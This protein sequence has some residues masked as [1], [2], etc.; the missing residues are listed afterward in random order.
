MSILPLRPGSG[1]DTKWSLTALL[2]RRILASAPPH[3]FEVL[4]R[5]TPSLPPNLRGSAPRRVSFQQQAASTFS[6]DN[7]ESVFRR[8]Y[9]SGSLTAFSHPSST[10]TNVFSAP[11]T[12]DSGR[13]IPLTEQLAYAQYEEALRQGEARVQA[14]AQRYAPVQTPVDPPPSAVSSSGLPAFVSSAERAQ[15]EEFMA[16]REKQVAQ[17]AAAPIVRSPSPVPASALPLPTPDTEFLSGPGNPEGQEISFHN[18]DQQGGDSGAAV[19]DTSV[20]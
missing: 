9:A 16:L 2:H 17:P 19:G 10:S 18:L 12:T 20:G 13:K 7:S 6:N 8:P 15:W 1:V 14:S 4:R 3:Q 11:T 5:L